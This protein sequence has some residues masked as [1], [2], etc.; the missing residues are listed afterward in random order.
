[1]DYLI[2]D[3]PER[4]EAN[5]EE[6]RRQAQAELNKQTNAP[7]AEEG[8]ILDLIASIKASSDVLLNDNES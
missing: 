3:D 5:Y 8:S 7:K 1:M 6:Y 4:D 2:P